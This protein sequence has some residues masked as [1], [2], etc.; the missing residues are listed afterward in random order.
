MATPRCKFSGCSAP[1]F[2]SLDGSIFPFCSVAHA[3]A[4]ASAP[5]VTAPPHDAHPQLAN[6]AYPPK[7][8]VEP[9]ASASKFCQ[10][11]GCLHLA[12]ID[13]NGVSAKYCSRKHRDAAQQQAQ[14]QQL[15]QLSP[16]SPVVV[17]KKGKKD[18][19]A[20]A[21]QIKAD[22]DFGAPLVYD[23]R[24]YKNDP[25]AYQLL[26]RATMSG[27][28]EQVRQALKLGGDSRAYF[29]NPEDPWSPVHYAASCG[30]TAILRILLEACADPDP[31]GVRS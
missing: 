31:Y 13:P 29:E 15:S 6:A 26:L 21:V 11:Q 25:V 8:G 18:E 20:P 10:F 28:E 16:A 5:P 22:P 4:A 14:Q 19:D 24:P 1:A 30:F 23:R 7:R 27:S 17:E 2:V 3:N 9:D 12:Y